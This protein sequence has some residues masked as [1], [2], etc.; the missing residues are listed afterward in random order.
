ME[1]HLARIEELFD[2]FRKSDERCE[3][4]F[5]ELVE[6]LGISKSANKSLSKIPYYENPFF[7]RM[8]EMHNIAV[9]NAIS[10]AQ[11]SFLQLKVN[12][13]NLMLAQ[14]PDNETIHAK[15]VSAQKEL[16]DYHHD[17]ILA[18]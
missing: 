11:T 10:Y 6:R 3:N 15:L 4:D 2:D 18:D 16:E 9:P 17:S 5:Q 12:V 14:E 13:Y 7:S 8:W 1:C